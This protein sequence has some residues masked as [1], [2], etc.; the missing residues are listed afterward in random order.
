MCDK[1]DVF[2]STLRTARKA[3]KCCECGIAINGGD[4]Y[5]YSSGIWNREP[6][7]YKQCESCGDIFEWASNEDSRE[8]GDGVGFT[9][10]REW[11]FRYMCRDFQGTEFLNH[12]ANKIGIE[13]EQL[14]L[15]LRI[16]TSKP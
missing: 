16:D 7:A 11:F 8:H 2:N 13:S 3:Y 6:A 14:N 10:L 15:L 4:K 12:F 9:D 1:P 5:R